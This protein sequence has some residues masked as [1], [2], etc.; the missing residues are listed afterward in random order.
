MA[1][2]DLLASLAFW[3]LPGAAAAATAGIVAGLAV[4]GL[5]PRMGWCWGALKCTRTYGR[6]FFFTLFLMLAFTV[7]GAA[8]SLA[9]RI[10][11]SRRLL[12]GLLELRT[13][14]PARL[15]HL[16]RSLGM[17]QRIDVVDEAAP[18]VFTHGLLR[19]RVLLSRGILDRL[20]DEEL[21]AVLAHERYHVLRHDPLRVLVAGAAADALFYL[22]AAG[23][24]HRWWDS[25]R[26]LAADAAA[27]VALGR[28]HLAQALH[29]LGS[30]REEPSPFAIAGAM[31]VLDLRITQLV[32]PERASNRIR[33]SLRAVAVASL[34]AGLLLAGFFGRCR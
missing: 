34:F 3:L 29:K 15:Q 6:W 16:A 7:A 26:E 20:S 30:W 4:H 14:A 32:H 22:P 10:R 27:V 31:G 2:Q 18:V 8:V 33:L 13:P 1:R 11:A 17:E 25:A 5:T 24:L 21:A 9:R 12:A 28:L 23:E 19:P